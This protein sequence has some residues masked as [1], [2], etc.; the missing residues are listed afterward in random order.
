M[1][2]LFA[3]LSIPPAFGT[4]LQGRQAGIDGARWRPLEAFHVTLRFFGEV[5]EDVARDLDGELSRIAARPF[6]IALKGAGSFADGDDIHAVWAGVADNPALTLLA[7]ACKS[8]ARR[9]GLFMIPEEVRPPRELRATRKHL[10]NAPPTPDFR[11]AVVD[12]VTNA[13]MCAIG[14]TR[15]PHDRRL[16]AVREATV[17]HALEVG[18]DKLTGKQKL[19]LLSDPFSLSALHLAVWSSPEHRAAWQA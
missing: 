6:D 14:T 15:F 11:Q 8:A 1:I 7:G 4:P 18:P 10:R 2:R 17:R 19:V 12:P 3:A 13:L 16:L 9:A 5:R